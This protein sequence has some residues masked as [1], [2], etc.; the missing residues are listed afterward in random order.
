MADSRDREFKYESGT[1][2]PMSLEERLDAVERALTDD[3]RGPADLSDAATAEAR[4]DELEDAVEELTD[5]V[6]ELEAATQALRGY[7]GNIRSV[8]R[9]V[10]QTA[11]AALA[12]AERAENRLDQ[13]APARRG[14]T[15]AGPSDPSHDGFAPGRSDEASAVDAVGPE[16][17]GGQPD[18][19][20]NDGLSER[21]ASEER[22]EDDGLVERLRDAL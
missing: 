19:W 4:L 17:A 14:P 1:T 15:A 21:A 7:V 18:T 13:E 6:A 8:N 11:E 10:E 5:R 12:A 3:D 22:R 20:T 2:H 16:T 9:D